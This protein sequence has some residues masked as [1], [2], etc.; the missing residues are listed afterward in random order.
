[1]VWLE[2]QRTTRWGFK[3]FFALL[4]GT[5][6][7]SGRSNGTK[8]ISDLLGSQQCRIIQEATTEADEYFN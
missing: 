7:S 6:C 8:C 3:S 2:N 1:M 4:L 5:M